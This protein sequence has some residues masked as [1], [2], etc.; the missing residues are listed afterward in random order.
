MKYVTVAV[1]GIRMASR[2][3]CYGKRYSRQIVK[4][5]CEEVA[6]SPHSSPLVAATEPKKNMA[7][8]TGQHAEDRTKTN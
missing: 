4:P 6:L 3:L 5:A 8:C 7:A 1:G 2:R